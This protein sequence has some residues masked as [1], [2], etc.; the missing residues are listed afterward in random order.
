MADTETNHANKGGEGLRSRNT[1]SVATLITFAKPLLF[2]LAPRALFPPSSSVPTKYRLSPALGSYIPGRRF[3]SLPL[4]AS[5]PTTS[6]ETARQ[7]PSLYSLSL[8]NSLL[9]P[10]SLQ[11]L[12]AS[13]QIPFTRGM[14]SWLSSKSLLG[15]YSF[16]KY[17]PRA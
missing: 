7:P 17:L 5:F 4:H 9:P 8:E 14:S 15:I 3:L 12:S 6:S 1:N 16:N 10:A 11:K 2:S 13:L